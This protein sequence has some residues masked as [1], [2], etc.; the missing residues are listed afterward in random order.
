M[1][2]QRSGRTLALALS[3]LLACILYSPILSGRIPFPSHLV[4][5]F[6]PWNSLP[7]D[8]VTAS[9]AE[10]GDLATQM[11]PWRTYAAQSIR[12]GVLPVWNPFIMGGT[13]FLANAQSALFY[14]PHLLFYVLPFSLAWSLMF[15]L[16]AVLA[17]F[18]TF[19]FLKAIDCDDWSAIAGGLIFSLCASM[20][21]RR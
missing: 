4:T 18:F 11:Y 12:E 1:T 9:H 7:G 6:A 20:S 15:G 13:P 14:P 17:G 2:T 21:L 10:I 19:L 16:H 5:D 8:A 3:L